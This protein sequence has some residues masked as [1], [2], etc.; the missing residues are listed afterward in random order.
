MSFREGAFAAVRNYGNEDFKWSFAA[1]APNVRDEAKPGIDR[2]PFSIAF[3]QIPP[4]AANA[5]D[6]QHAVQ[7]TTVILSRAG[8]STSLWMKQCFN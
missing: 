8:L 7:K 5:Q 3:M 2:V 1:F 4:S 6:M